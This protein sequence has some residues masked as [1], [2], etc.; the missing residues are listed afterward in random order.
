MLNYSVHN[1]TLQVYWNDFLVG[2]LSECFE[3]EQFRLYEL[4]EEVFSQSDFYNTL[5]R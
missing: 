1:E 4:A 3:T 5:E 2:E